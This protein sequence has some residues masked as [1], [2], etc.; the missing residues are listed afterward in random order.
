M[1]AMALSELLYGF[2]EAEKRQ[3]VRYK[4]LVP[5]GSSSSPVLLV[6]NKFTNEC[7]T[8]DILNVCL[9]CFTYSLFKTRRVSEWAS[10]LSRNIL[11]RIDVNKQEFFVKFD[12]LKKVLVYCFTFI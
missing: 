8:A 3:W 1:G 12:L 10:Y 5:E 11:I 2:L 7:L 4:I 9:I 6:F